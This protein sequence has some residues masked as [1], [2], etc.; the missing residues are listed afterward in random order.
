MKK[1]IFLLLLSNSILSQE[2]IIKE[3]KIYPYKYTQNYEHFKR[4]VLS[5]SDSNI[6][7]I[8]DFNYEWGY[9]YVLKVKEDYIGQMSDG[10][11]YE[12]TLKEIISKKKA[13][14]N[15]EFEMVVDPLRYYEILDEK[16]IVNYTLEK[17]NDSTYYYMDE[18]K[19]EIPKKLLLIFENYKSNNKGFLGKFK[20]V[21]DE[22]IRLISLK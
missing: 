16:E 6:E 18:I 3:I 15:Y 13:D 11:N 17:I 2:S 4:L 14:H 22:I 5:S 12:Y 8:K 9:Y 7:F 1:I 10:S 19:I 21:S 20:F